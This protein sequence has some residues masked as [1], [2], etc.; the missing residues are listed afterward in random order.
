MNARSA[1][2][3]DHPWCGG[4]LRLVA[5]TDVPGSQANY[6]TLGTLPKAVLPG[7]ASLVMGLDSGVERR[8]ANGRCR[9]LRQHACHLAHRAG[10]LPS[11]NLT[12]FFSH[13]GGQ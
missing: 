10:P 12:T 9:V 5:L 4:W 2:D 7:V 13:M 8:H 1:S 6:L 11:V 3:I